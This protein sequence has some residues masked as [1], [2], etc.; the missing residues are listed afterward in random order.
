MGFADLLRELHP[1]LITGAEGM[2]N[3]DCAT[4]PHE[5]FFHL[6]FSTWQEAKLLPCLKYLRGN[7]HLHAPQ[8]WVD[9]F[10]RPF[11]VLHIARLSKGDNLR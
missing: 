2:P 9:V 11:E 6:P 1:G 4:S 8:D 7:R 5:V 10:P 3:V